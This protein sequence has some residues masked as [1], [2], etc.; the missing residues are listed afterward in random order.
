MTRINVGIPPKN[1]T[2]QHL[3]AEHREIKRIC[4]LYSAWKDKPSPIPDKFSLGK[5]HVKFFLNKGKYTR[6]RYL[7]IYEECIA[8]KF[9]VE[10]YSENWKVYNPEHFQ[11]YK[12][13]QDDKILIFNRIH[14]RIVESSQI[15]LY[16]GQKVMKTQAIVRLMD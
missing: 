16:Y 11:D 15:P 9:K 5:G 7:Q 6:D 10:N 13:S 3:L 2:D 4:S 1:L 14:D 12:P 8:R